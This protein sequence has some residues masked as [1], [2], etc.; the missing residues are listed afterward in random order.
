MLLVARTASGQTLKPQERLCDPT[1]QHCRA[2]ILTYIQQETVGI[3]MGFWM[4]TDAR[5]ANELVRAWNRGVRIRLLM[6]PRCEEAHESCGPQNEQLRA[7]G[8]PMRN[9]LPG[10]ILHWKMA[11]FAGQGQIQF[12][13]ANYAPFEMVPDQ[14]Y[15]NFTDEVVFFSNNQSLVRSFMTKFDDLWTSTTEFGNYAN[16]SGG[17][18]RRYAKYPIDPE[19]NFPPDDSYRT[20]ALAAYAAERQRI[21]VLMFRI[22]D[23]AHTDAMIQAVGRGVPV[24]LITDETEYRNPSRLWDSYNV[25]RMYSAGVQVRMDGHQ[26]LNHEKAVIL[27]G[28]GMSIFGSSNWTSPSS[29]S[30][31]EHTYFTIKPWI[32]SWLR[33]QFD[34]KWTNQTGFSETKPF[35][36]R[37]PD[38]P[39]YALPANGASNVPATG[40]TLS[41]DAG[42]WAHNYDIY[43]GLTPD[44]PLLVANLRLGPSQSTSDLRSHA[45]GPLLPGTRYYWKVVSKTMAFVPAAGQVWSFVTAGTAP[46]LATATDLDGDGRSDLAVFRKA[47]GTWMTLLSGQSYGASQSVAWGASADIPLAGDFDGDGRMDRTVYRPSNGTWYILKSGSGFTASVTVQWGTA[48]DI[49]LQGDIDGDGR[50]DPIVWRP[51]TGTWYWLTSS[52]GYSYASAGAKQWGS[53]V[54]GDQPLVG[55]FDGDGRADLAVWRASNGTWYWLV[56]AGGYQYA[57]ARGVQWGNALLGDQPLVGDFDGDG[58]SDLTVWRADGTWFWLTSS[59]QYAYAAARLVQWGR[60]SLGD[61][62]LLADFDG[63][64]R[65][66]PGVWRPSTGTWFWLTSSSGYSYASSGSRQWGAT[67]DVPVV[68]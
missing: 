46:R 23:E 21:D 40:V 51:S 45:V 66:D 17:V 12:A 60:A 26:G 42:L 57:A 58:R 5:Y 30:Q 63:D 65:S 34:R 39:A 16:V 32:H 3:D 59:T 18:T 2:D 10:G 64:R 67:G 9:R 31:R 33:D 52:T 49:P 14:P 4:M 55:D 53:A 61:V 7:A 50:A 29:D 36:P 13:G 43:I 56:A 38:V 68:R 11:L 15:V 22:T 8:I 1:F 27:R 19:L 44:P 20:R 25:D 47:S 48:T 35:V 37:P 28:T 41:W 24:R 54:L 62:P 6:D